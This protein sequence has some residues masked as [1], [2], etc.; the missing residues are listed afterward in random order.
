MMVQ[1]KSQ[2]GGGEKRKYSLQL[3]PGEGE[4]EEQDPETFLMGSLD[5]R[6]EESFLRSPPALGK[7]KENSE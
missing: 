7:R 2:G 1:E 5:K 4:E 3:L 6:K